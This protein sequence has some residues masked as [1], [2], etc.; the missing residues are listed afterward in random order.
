VRAYDK[1]VEIVDQTRVARFGARNRQIGRRAA[2]DS[3]EFAHLFAVQA[4]ERHAV[5]SVSKSSRRCHA[6]L[7]SLMKRFEDIRERG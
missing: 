4:A 6:P 1:A 2:I 7:R 5:S 3:T